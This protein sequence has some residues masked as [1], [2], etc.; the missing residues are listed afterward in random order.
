[1]LAQ[2]DI[3]HYLL[4]LGL[5][6]PREVVEENLEIVDTSRRNHVFVAAVRGGP[7]YVVK[8]AGPRTAPTLSHEAAVLRVLAGAPE[9]AAQV[10]IVVHHEPEASLLVLRSAGNARDWHAYL[11]AARFPRVPPRALGRALASLH[12][13][14]ADFVDDPPPG[15]DPMWG[16]SLPEPSY[17]L[18]LDLSVAAQDLVA[19]LQASEALC[20]RLEELRHARLG[21]SLV[22]GDLRWE[23]CLALP[24]PGSRRRTRLLLADWE[25][26]GRG[27]PEFDVGTVLAEYLCAW[28]ASIPIVEPG[29]PGRSV[30]RAGHPLR[31]MHPAIHAFWRAYG[32]DNPNRP[33]LE[34]V[35]ALAAVRILQTA[36]EHAQNLATPSAHLI[37]L[38]Q[39]ADKMLRNPEEAA[40]SLLGLRE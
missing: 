31:S 36:I 14:P 18:L 33:K 39:L 10:P 32:L 35:A 7:T 37:T 5:V 34:L 9:L 15:V 40:L 6:K 26:A 13:L 38:V 19:R 25:L 24:A 22:H 11:I 1:M 29:N 16:L 8:Q 28:V 2:S 20:D 17:E 21:S 30:A 4:S 27:A 23:N 12:R 3:A